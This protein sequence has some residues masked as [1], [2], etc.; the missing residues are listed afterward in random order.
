[1]A[2]TVTPTITPAVPAQVVVPYGVTLEEAEKRVLIMTIT[3]ARGNKKLAAQV[4]GISRSALYAKL[5]RFGLVEQYATH[6]ESVLLKLDA[7]GSAPVPHTPTPPT[8][9][10]LDSTSSQTT[11][12]QLIV[13]VPTATRSAPPHSGNPDDTPPLGTRIIP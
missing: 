1:M 11:T 5:R 8:P 10:P 13:P 9:A 4:L 3:E 12:A 2:D 6:R 7:C